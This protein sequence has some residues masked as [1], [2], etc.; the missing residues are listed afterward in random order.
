MIS[1]EKEQAFLYDLYVTPDWSERFAELIDEHITLPKE[2]RVLYVAPGTGSHALALALRAG[3]EVEIV[4]IDESPER[5]ALAQAKQ[6][7]AQADAGTEFR[8]GQLDALPFEDA[9]FDFVIGDLSLVPAYRLPETL[10][11][12]T[13]VARD[14]STVALA[15][16]TASSFGEFFSLY[17]EALAGIGEGEHAALVERLI[18]E[19]PTVTGTEALATLEGLDEVQSWTAREEFE[20]RS[21]EEFLNAP[22]VNSFLLPDWLASLPEENTRDEVRARLQQLID[23]E[24]HD[25]ET[26]W[27][28]SIKATVIV[29][30]RG[31]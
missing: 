12:M 6:Q 1:N 27:A 21:G 24:D 5:T 16:V 14:G 4:G 29:G 25:E 23:D 30:Q 17:W 28:F 20:Y 13:R 18:N 9:A 26:P 2:G 31:E 10:A 7:A 3:S 22:L 11:E 15:I 19:L 8:T